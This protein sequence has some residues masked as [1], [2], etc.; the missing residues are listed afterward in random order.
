MR[1][2]GRFIIFTAS[3]AVA[4]SLADFLLYGFSI[5][6]NF[7]ALLYLAAILAAINLTIRPIIKFLLTPFIILTLGILSLVINAAL[8]Y[9]L[10]FS[11]S[12]I[13]ISSITD[14]GLATL[15]IWAINLISSFGARLAYNKKS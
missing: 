4:L 7:I 15:I 2:I 10:D 14:L 11:S 13:T 12:D 5:S 1:F 9:F 3:N 8:I 6:S